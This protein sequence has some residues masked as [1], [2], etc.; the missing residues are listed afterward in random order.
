[1]ACHTVPV[2][3]PPQ[4]TGAVHGPR[5]CTGA[6]CRDHHRIR[7]MPHPEQV[8]RMRPFG[9]RPTAGAIT[10]T[11]N[12]TGLASAQVRAQSEL[13]TSSA[14]P[15]T[16][17]RQPCTRVSAGSQSIVCALSSSEDVPSPVRA[18]ADPHPLRE[19]RARTAHQGRV[20]SPGHRDRAPP[21]RG[22][23]RQ[24]QTPRQPRRL[25]RTRTR[26]LHPAPTSDA[27]PDAPAIRFRLKPTKRRRTPSRNFLGEFPRWLGTGEVLVSA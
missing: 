6:A 14:H 11:R 13:P 9:L 2:A 16:H 24:G 3:T 1:M 22:H 27:T 25:H 7:C 4:R 8:V 17:H 19:C 21:R 23:P 26:T 10:R 18:P 5:G 15:S 20:P 12:P